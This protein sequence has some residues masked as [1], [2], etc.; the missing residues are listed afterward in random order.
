[1][2][3]SLIR[4]MTEA[5]LEQVLEWRNHIDIRK[6]MYTQDKISMS[7]HVKWYERCSKMDTK[8]LLIFESHGKSLGFINFS[9][10]KNSDISDW[11]FYVAP[12]AAKGSGRELGR[13]AINFAFAELKFHKICGQAL[14]YNERSINFHR[15]LGFQKEGVLRDQYQVDKQFYSVVCFGLL[16]K[17]WHMTFKER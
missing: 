6:Y 3:K 2:S 16:V 1:M 4:R 10:I 14:S 9:R 7:E 17:E 12:N 15:S 13:L 8:T 5:D 11:G